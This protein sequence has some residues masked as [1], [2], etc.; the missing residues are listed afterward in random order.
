MSIPLSGTHRL[1]VIKLSSWGYLNGR[2]NYT[3]GASGGG[4]TNVNSPQVDVTFKGK[5]FSFKDILGKEQKINYTLV[6]G[7]GEYQYNSV[8]VKESDSSVWWLLSAEAEK[9]TANGQLI[10]HGCQRDLSDSSDWHFGPRTYNIIKPDTPF[11]AGSIVCF[12]TGTLLKT[13]AGAVAVENL[14]LHD[15]VTVHH[16]GKEQ[17]GRITCIKKGQTTIR[18][19]IMPDVA[20]YPVRIAKN[21]IAKGIPSKDLLLMPEQRLL[22]K[23]RFVP[24]RLLMNNRSIFYDKTI[25]RYD[26]VHIEIEENAV[27]MANGVLTESGCE[28][29]QASAL[30]QKNMMAAFERQSKK[31]A[32]EA[33]ASLE[34]DYRFVEP[35]YQK[36][37]KRAEKLHVP[38]REEEPPLT[39]DIALHL[40]TETGKIIRAART[41]EGRVLFL[42]PHDVET[43]RIVSNASRP[44]DVIGP[45]MDDR[46]YFG[47]AIGEVKIFR[48]NKPQLITEHLN[49]QDLSGW[50]PLETPAAR[51]TTGNAFLPLGQGR[52]GEIALLSI[53]VV[54]AALYVAPP[55]VLPTMVERRTA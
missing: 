13:P 45:F 11:N 10:T 38:L 46:R 17:V 25:T 53:Q 36:L 15:Q 20:G 23:G 34:I 21:A 42:I 55:P 24:A 19:D 47:V 48:K 27:I 6:A 40:V 29:G 9:Y 7:S 39:S 31:W 33:T 35:L 12:L 14:K 37:L 41:I 43:V 1:N 26:Y 44:C 3:I 54:E 30:T 4:T 32:I 49:A 52:K 16:F 5:S 50:L 28:S 18:P 8:I 51:W 2:A 22:F